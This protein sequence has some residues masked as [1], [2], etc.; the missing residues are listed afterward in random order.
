MRHFNYF[1]NGGPAPSS[2]L[3]C[4]NPK[5]L[6]DLGREIPVAGGMAQVC[7]TCVI[8]LA[9]A[10]GYIEAAPIQAIVKSAKEDIA[11]LEQEIQKIPNLVDG[12]INGIR[13]S[14]TDF[15]FAISYSDNP[16]EPEVVSDISV[17]DSGEHQASKAAA[18]QRKTSSKS[19]S[20]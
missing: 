19:I 14:V 7:R 20:E 4:G 13:S 18:G 5:Q 10:V 3:S 8:E 12:L 9:A 2:C 15:I 6:F 17:S 1:E 11:R 16:S